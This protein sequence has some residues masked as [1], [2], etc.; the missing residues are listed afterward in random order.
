MKYRDCNATANLFDIK[1]V[2]NLFVE[3]CRFTNNNVNSLF[4]IQNSIA[5]FSDCLVDNNVN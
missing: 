4:G 3:K 1:L 2:S 5:K